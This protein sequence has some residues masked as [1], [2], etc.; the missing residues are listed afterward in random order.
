M[1]Q[2]A[3][4][5]YEEEQTGKHLEQDILDES[6]IADG[7]VMEENHYGVNIEALKSILEDISS[8]DSSPNDGEDEISNESEEK[9]NNVMRWGKRDRGN[10]LPSGMGWGKNNVM[11]WG[12]RNN[13]MRWG[14]RNNVMRW[15]K[16]NNVMRWG[17][18]NN[19]MRWGKR[20][21]VMR[22]GKR[23]NVMR[24]G[25]RNNVMRWGKRVADDSQSE[26]YW[27]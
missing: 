12:K 24:W 16:R 1:P 8:M 26:F 5:P 15:G 22:W 3:T 2:S 27:E 19:V 10:S 17:K 13:V 4:S 11:R 21:N 23:N 9:R 14:K 7:E 20:N 6:A 18:R 25:K